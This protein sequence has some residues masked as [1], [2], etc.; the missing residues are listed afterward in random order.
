MTGPQNMPAA[1][2][3]IS[4]EDVAALVESQYPPLA[5][6]PIVEVG[7]GWD[8][9]MFRVGETHVARFPRRKVSSPMV[10]HEATWLPR[11]A[12]GLPIDV[13]APIF[14]GS[15]GGSYPWAWTIAP[16]IEGE[17]ATTGRYDEMVC[18][19]Q[20]G[21]FL[22]AFHGRA[23]VDYPRNQFRGGPIAEK[24]E[25]TTSRLDDLAGLMDHGLKDVFVEDCAAPA[26]DGPP[27]W[28]HGDLHPNN[29]VVRDR[30][31][32]GIIDFTDL[33]AGD[34]ACDLMIGWSMFGP[35]GRRAM[36]GAYSWID[37]DMIRRAR[38]WA[39]HHGS[40]CV[41]HGEDNEVM[42]QMGL[43]TLASVLED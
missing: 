32:A 10:A 38:A 12:P 9:F 20:I 34:P 4:I 7:F 26:Y 36:F 18:A 22:S 2:I 3:E 27:R 19:V 21:E 39:V 35:A 6:E 41:G 28:L 40:V 25:T 1:D 37:D 11:I 16:W 43:R 5:G 14:E 29:V 31:V 24:L 8:N 15:P 30:R 42:K 33:T 23:P 17:A 13:P